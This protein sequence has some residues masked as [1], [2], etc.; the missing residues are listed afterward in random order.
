VHDADRLLWLPLLEATVCAIPEL[1]GGPF[2]R[3]TEVLTSERAVHTLVHEASYT[4]GRVRDSRVRAWYSLRT[5][6]LHQFESRSYHS[7][8][9]SI[10]CGTV[11]SLRGSAFTA[12]DSTS[13]NVEHVNLG[14]NRFSFGKV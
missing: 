4:F 5:L 3:P 1:H 12:T 2:S 14:E 6:Q 8:L 13:V 11:S 10:W 9:H 7:P